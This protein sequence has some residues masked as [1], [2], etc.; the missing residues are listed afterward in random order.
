MKFNVLAVCFLVGLTGCATIMDGSTETLSVQTTNGPASVA[1][2]QCALSNKE[3]SWTVTTPNSVIVHRGS[4]ALNVQCTK[5]GFVP[6]TQMVKASTN[7]DVYGNIL[8][9]G[10]IGA[11]IDTT[12]GAAWDYPKSI[13][14]P[15]QPA[16][17]PVVA[18]N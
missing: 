15:M 8:I 1:S 3:G 10:G 11:T 6:E 2:A 5:D 12:N 9:G 4:E 7:G 18:S 14:V 16:T 13:T 17:G